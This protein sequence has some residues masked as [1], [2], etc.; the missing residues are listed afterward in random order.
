MLE[1][2]LA[3]DQRTATAPAPEVRPPKLLK[4]LTDDAPDDDD[5]RLRRVEIVKSLVSRVVIEDR[6]DGIATFTDGSSTPTA[7]SRLAR[8]P[9]DA[10]PQTVRKHR[11][12]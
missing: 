12:C 9:S 7:R 6:D 11:R 1:N 10:F 2:T 4:L 5:R 8:E 3:V